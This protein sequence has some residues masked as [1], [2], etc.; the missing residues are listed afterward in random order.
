MRANKDSNGRMAGFPLSLYRRFIGEPK[1]L[2]NSDAIAA[3]FGGV[4]R[5][6]AECSECVMVAAFILLPADL[7]GGCSG[8]S[9]SCGTGLVT[10]V[11]KSCPT[12]TVVLP[13]Q[14]ATATCR[15]IF[16]VKV[17]LEEVS[18]EEG[19]PGDPD[20]SSEGAESASGSP[21]GGWGIISD[22]YWI[23]DLGTTHNRATVLGILK[24]GASPLCHCQSFRR[25]C[26]GSGGDF[27]LAGLNKLIK[28]LCGAPFPI[29]DYGCSHLGYCN[30][31]VIKQ[32]T[33]GIAGE[34]LGEFKVQLVPAG[35]GLKGLYQVTATNVPTSPQPFIWPFDYVPVNRDCR[36]DPGGCT[37]G[38]AETHALLCFSLSNSDAVDGIVTKQG[39]VNPL[40][41][42]H[43]VNQPA[44]H[45]LQGTT[46]KVIDSAATDTATFDDL[47]LPGACRGNVI[48]FSVIGIS[49]MPSYVCPDPGAPVMHPAPQF[50]VGMAP[51]G[52]VQG[53]VH[54]E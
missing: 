19:L 22:G 6:C 25:P 37:P 9:Y 13:L 39:G 17:S 52:G 45:Q 38:E 51:I 32:P 41:G 26:V 3:G 24:R 33:T 42:R 47:V 5:G 34:V 48:A 54:V 12:G 53:G 8:Y 15:R 20:F 11:F 40:D 28:D 4:S 43:Y 44:P 27:S 35:T 10:G 29:T 21:Y 31:V 2:E 46:T 14:S 18:D 7:S 23:N 50:D 36:F 30:P 49:D 16:Y 1:L